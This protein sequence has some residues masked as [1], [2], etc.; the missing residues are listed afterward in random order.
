[1]M[2]GIVRLLGLVVGLL[3]RTVMVFRVMVLCVKLR[4]RWSLLCSVMKVLLVW[5]V[6]ELTERL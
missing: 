2:I 1:M 5:A 4:L 3:S 6:C